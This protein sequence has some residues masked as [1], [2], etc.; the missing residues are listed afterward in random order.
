MGSD[1]EGVRSD[2][3]CIRSEFKG[4]RSDFAGY[5]IQIKRDEGPE[6]KG[7]EKKDAGPKKKGLNKKG[8]GPK[9]RE[10]LLDDIPEGYLQYKQTPIV[11]KLWTNSGFQ[12]LLWRALMGLLPEGS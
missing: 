6:K 9:K 1:F 10:A 2:L 5:E 7:L 4:V 3:D 12:D 11:R 8:L